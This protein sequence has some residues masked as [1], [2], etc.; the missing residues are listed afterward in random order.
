MLGGHTHGGQIW[1]FDYVVQ[2][3]YPLL[4]GRYRVE[5]MTVLVHRGTGT[6]GPRM[7][8]W[9]PG[10]ILQVVLLAESSNHAGKERRAADNEQS[11]LD[12]KPGEL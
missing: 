8:L 9:K 6:W 12:S 2:Q 10:V 11:K 1:P 3:Q 5:G 4:E 7:R